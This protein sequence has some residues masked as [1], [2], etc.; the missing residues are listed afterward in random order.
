MPLELTRYTEILEI[1]GDVLKVRVPDTGIVRLGEEIGEMRPEAAAVLQRVE[2]IV[3]GA[4]AE[5]NGQ[6]AI[7]EGGTDAGGRRPPGRG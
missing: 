6:A 5:D 4:M 7:V 1:V 2:C 3:A